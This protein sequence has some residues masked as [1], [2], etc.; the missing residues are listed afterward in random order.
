MPGT[1]INITGTTLNSNAAG[2]LGSTA[3]VNMNGGTFSVGASQT[4]SAL[5][6]ISTGTDQVSLGSGVVLTVGSTDN[7]SST[8]SGTINGNGSLIKA[9][10]GTL[11]LAGVNG[12]T[13]GTTIQGGTLVISNS[14]A[15]GPN[16]ITLAGG[17]LRFTT[18]LSNN[19]NVTGPSTLDVTG[20][21]ADSIT[22]GFT[23][24]TALLNVT[25]GSTGTNVPYTLTLTGQ[26]TLSGSP[27]I[28]VSNNGTV[29]ET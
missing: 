25:G 29:A 20:T 9:G 13:G 27:F 2:A 6:S 7:L 16:T 17:G 18:A 3:T 10:A 19:F 28:A 23:L 21:N 26:T 12:Y 14:S 15:I 5:N 8:F 24:G 11:T 22:G 4:I 1:V